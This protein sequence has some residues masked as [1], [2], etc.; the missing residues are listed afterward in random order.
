MLERR[1]ETYFVDRVKDLGGL[2]LKFNSP[3]CAGVPDRIVV[4]K[5]QVLFVELKALKKRPRKLQESIFAK[6]VSQGVPVYILNSID[7]VDRFIEG[8]K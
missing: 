6:I 7:Q 2:C 4:F 5:G 1:I 8:L 3:N